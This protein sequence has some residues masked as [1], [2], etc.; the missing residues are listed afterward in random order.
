MNLYKQ[1]NFY[2]SIIIIFFNSLIFTQADEV[3]IVMKVNNEIITNIDIENEYTYLI[4]LN[5]NLES[6]DKKKILL[7]AKESLIKEKI[8][9]IEIL[10]YFELNKKNSMI[11]N[12]IENVFKNLNFRNKEEF[13]NHLKDYDIS[14]D[15]VYRKIE[16]ETVW[17]QII[18]ERYKNKIVINEEN[19]R[20][21]IINNPKKI[22]SILLSEIVFDYKNKDEIENKYQEIIKSIN[23]H[24]F[25]ESV[26]KFSISESRNNFGSLGWVNE[27]I[28]SN[29]IKDQIKSLEIGEISNPIITSSGILILKLEDKKIENYEVDIDEELIR[30]KKFQT[31]NQLNNFSIIYFNKVKN[32]L[33]I[34]EY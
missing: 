21:K 4:A 32:K 20:Q 8:K 31:N 11:D 26:I 5:K 9:K 25:K 13:V 27:N 3:E 1:I 34:N 24:G 6:I 30:I 23:I 22:K 12:V 16:I 2:I 7:L 29:K 17:N 15:E 28:L 18:Y 14:F 19:L 10:K 33:I